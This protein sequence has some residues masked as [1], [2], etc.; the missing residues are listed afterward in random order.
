MF[1]A[2]ITETGVANDRKW[3]DKLNLNGCVGAFKAY[4]R[5]WVRNNGLNHDFDFFRGWCKFMVQRTWSNAADDE[6][7][8]FV[9]ILRTFSNGGFGTSDLVSHFYKRVIPRKLHELNP[10][11]WGA[12]L[13]LLEDN[14]VYFTRPDQTVINNFGDG[15]TM[16]DVVKFKT[17]FPIRYSALVRLGFWSLRRPGRDW[18]AGSL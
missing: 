12:F 11:R 9:F 5:E 3:L 8:L 13:G 1:V 7:D 18:T 14:S 17:D 4:M 10:Q 15:D 16:N 6:W 2:P